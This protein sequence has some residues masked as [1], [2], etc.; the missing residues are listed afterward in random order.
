MFIVCDLNCPGIHWQ[1]SFAPLDGV[2]D[3]ILECLEE[4]GFVQC[5]SWPT[6]GA[7]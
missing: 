7:N 5:V 6:R 4:F 3:K 1:S 2:Q